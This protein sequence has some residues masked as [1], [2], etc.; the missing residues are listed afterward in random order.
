M[1]ITGNVVQAPAGLIGFDT[2]DVLDAARANEY[3]RRGYQFCIRYVPF[4][5][6][7]EYVDLTADEAQII[8]DSGLALM[9][10]QHPLDAGWAPDAGL[11]QAFGQN[12]ALHAGNAGLPPGV[13]V[14]LDLEGVRPG[15]P[16]AD[17]IAYCNAWFQEVEN[18]GFASGIYIGANPGL[19]ADQLY[20]DIR[21]SHYWK[22][23]SSAEAGVPDEIPHRGYQLVQRI[24][25]P[26]PDEFDSDVTKTDAFGGGVMWVV[27]S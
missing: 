15:A 17:V 7:S 2:I 6:R 21:T 25:D 5:G 27:N 26:G 16:A 24:N 12:A 8:V 19:T 10:V 20:W 14:W 4:D 9:V 23:G 18:A 1:T 11:G 22:G 3:V 13:N